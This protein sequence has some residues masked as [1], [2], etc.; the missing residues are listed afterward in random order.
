MS[1]KENN[2]HILIVLNEY[3]FPE[4]ASV[5]VDQDDAIIYAQAH[6]K[7][8]GRMVL[9][10]LTDKES[11]FGGV[12]QLYTDKGKESFHSYVIVPDKED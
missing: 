4:S 7:A 2:M 12:L 6:A 3:A 1:P 8:R 10:E 11:N 5:F 9:G